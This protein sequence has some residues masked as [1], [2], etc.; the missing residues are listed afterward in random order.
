MNENTPQVILNYIK[1]QYSSVNSSENA[2]EVLKGISLEIQK[3]ES[4]AFIGPSGCG[5]STLLNLIGALDQPTA[6]SIK[7]NDIQLKEQSESE[8]AKIRNRKIGFVFQA[9]H[10]LPQCTVVENI[11]IPT[12]INKNCDPEENLKY[13]KELLER[14]GLTNREDH[15]PGQLSGGEKQRVALVRALIN[16]PQLLLADEPTGQLDSQN[17]IN[18]MDLLVELNRETNV[19]LICVT[20]SNELAFKM[21]K[22]FQL[23]DGLL[24]QVENVT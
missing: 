4:I 20:H 19:T 1:H 21:K 8:L 12:L 9:H 3:G 15:R 14:V 13:A 5:K 7:L 22:V 24:H 6:G 11:L 2:V 10:L 16:K 18:L 23:K 17:A